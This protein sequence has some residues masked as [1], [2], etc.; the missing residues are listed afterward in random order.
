[1]Y[2][3]L[4]EPIPD[5]ELYLKRLG[6]ASRPVLDKSYLDAL[7]F[8]HQCRIPFEN[9]DVYEY[10]RPISLGITD[11]YNK[12]ILGGRGG[13]C[14]ELNALFTRFLQALG[15][16]ASSCMCRILRNKNFLPPILHRGVI[17]DI[18]GA[19]YFCDVG[20]GGPTPPASILVADGVEANFGRETYFVDK[21]DDFWWTLSR[22]TSAGDREKIIQFYTMPQDNVNFITMNFYCSQSPDSVFTQKLFLNI[23]T[24]DGVNSVLGNLFTQTRNGVTRKHTIESRAELQDIMQNCFRLPVQS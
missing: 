13:Y 19:K 4:Y 8:A 12:V 14:F 3:N 23:R 6:T 11:L 1:M 18:E 7:V 10:H 24:E 9:L 22:T 17:V 15:F 5:T 2:E 16:Q 20:Y 21:A